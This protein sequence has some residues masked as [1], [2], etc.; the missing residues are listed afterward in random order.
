[1]SGILGIVPVM[2][3]HRILRS[4]SGFQRQLFR[5]RIAIDMLVPLGHGGVQLL[6]LFKQ[7]CAISH[8]LRSVVLKDIHRL[9][10]ACFQPD[11][12]ACAYVFD[13]ALQRGRVRSDRM[14]RQE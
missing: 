12:I 9:S 6:P 11:K 14:R 5:R 3:Q 4:H 7:Q 1:V 8:F 10:P 13:F 2:N